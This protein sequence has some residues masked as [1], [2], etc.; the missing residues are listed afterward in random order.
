MPEFR[1]KAALTKLYEILVEIFLQM[2]KK[3]FFSKEYVT[4]SSCFTHLSPWLNTKDNQRISHVGI[5]K[6]F[7]ITQF[8][9]MKTLLKVPF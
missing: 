1:F 2:T 3:A 6:E 9:K 5:L 7:T 8:P 4:I